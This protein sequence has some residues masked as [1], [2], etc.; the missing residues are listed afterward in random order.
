MKGVPILSVHDDTFSTVGKI[1]SVLGKIRIRE[2][3]KVLKTKEIIEKE[4]DLKR[5]L[6]ELKIR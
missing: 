5:M 6:K 3:E 1:E 2:Q 4:F